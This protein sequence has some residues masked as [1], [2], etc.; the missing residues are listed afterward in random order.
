MV[1]LAILGYIFYILE[2]MFFQSNTQFTNM[3]RMQLSK[4]IKI[5]RFD[6]AHKYFLSSFRDLPLHGTLAQQSCIYTPAQNR[7]VEWKHC[8]ILEMTCAFMLFVA[9][10]RHF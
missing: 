1:F 9:M 2:L 8:H 6:G 10:T 3:I 7:V 5:L 4:R